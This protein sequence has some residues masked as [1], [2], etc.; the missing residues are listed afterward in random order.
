MIRQYRH[1]ELAV[2][3][4]SHYYNTQ[5]NYHADYY[6]IVRS[7]FRNTDIDKCARRRVGYR[8]FSGHRV[9]GHLTK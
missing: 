9:I 8:Y 2:L 7:A 6:L 4:C 5:A 1:A 3:A